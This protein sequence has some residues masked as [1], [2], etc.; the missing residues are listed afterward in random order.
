[1]TENRFTDILR[2]PQPAF[3]VMKRHYPHGLPGWSRKKDCLVELECMGTWPRAYDLI[4]A[5]GVTE[6]EMLEHLLFTYQYAFAKVDARPLP[7]GKTVK[8][9]DLDGLTMGDLRSPGFKLIAQV[10]AMLSMNYPQRLHRCFLIN[11]PGWWAVAWK[12]ISPIVP[13]KV[14]AQMS[15]FSKN[16]KEQALKSMLEWIDEDVIPVAYGGKNMLPLCQCSLEVAMARFV[17]KLNAHLPIEEG[18]EE[19][20]S[21]LGGSSDDGLV[22]DS[23]SASVTE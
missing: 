14:R 12:L 22:Y 4:A 13:A 10:G 3:T 8:I 7:D 2:R 17:G 9:V 11:A 15:L 5:E 18:D 19:E 21:I 20:E 6:K 16:D 23:P 1:M